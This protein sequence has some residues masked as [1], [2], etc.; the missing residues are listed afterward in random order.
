MR[1][2]IDA[3]HGP[4][5]PGK[6]T[7]D[8]S[9]R[10]F[11]FNSVVARCV[12]DGLKQYEGV[13]VLFTHA[14]DRDVPLKERTDKANAWKADAF[15]SIHANAFG[16]DWND[17]NGIETFVYTSRPTAAVKL[18]EAVQRSLVRSTG[19][20][21]RGVKAGDLHVLR[22]TKM[23]AIL[24]ECGF[25][26]NRE[27]AALL[28]SDEYRRKCAAAIVQAI[29]EVYG[30][31]KVGVAT[32]G[33]PIAGQAQATIGQAQEWARQ[34]KAAQAFID[35]APIYWRVGAVLGIRPEVGYAQ[36]AKET[37]FG[38][39]GGVVS[40]DFHNWCGLKTT[41]GGSN[42]DPTAH[43]R[44]PS[45]EVGV[46]AHLQHLALYAGVEVKGEIVDPRHFPSV[47]GTAKTVESLGGK[48]APAADYGKAITELLA[49]LLTTKVSTTPVDK[50]V[51][52]VNIQINGVR[53]P[54]QGYLRNGVSVLP[55]RVVSE[56]LGVTPEWLPETKQ[57][58]VNGKD[59]TETIEAGVSYA[60]ARELAA[61]LGLQVDWEG[62]YKT[63]TLKGET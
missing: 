9:M 55:I 59:L 2:A 7:P 26:T 45:D 50:S 8:D 24:A 49:G 3:G 14:D 28:K 54:A 18:A 17:A 27:E 33:T 38:R 16:S 11:H 42:T 51:E 10:E 19:R 21:D 34:K 35:V 30:L 44:F 57:V 62:T 43:A 56:A 20:R 41:K 36:A 52:K 46:R 29:A 61:V 60:P 6:R 63:V 4:N 40:R 37:G 48:W 22:E 13:E 31:K 47:R 1:I 25:M 53:I 39:F 15:F 12:R 23:T 58:R 5:T 32:S